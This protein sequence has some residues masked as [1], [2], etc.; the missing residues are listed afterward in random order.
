MFGPR[1]EKVAQVEFGF[2]VI[3]ATS[4]QFLQGLSTEK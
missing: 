2:G 4:M 3:A 1:L